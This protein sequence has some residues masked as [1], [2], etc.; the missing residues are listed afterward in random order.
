[1]GD[2]LHLLCNKHPLYDVNLALDAPCVTNNRPTPTPPPPMTVNAKKQG[3]RRKERNHS[4]YFASWLLKSGLLY[5][6]I[7]SFQCR[8]TI[9]DNTMTLNVRHERATWNCVEG[10]DVYIN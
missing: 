1:M 10:L 8:K 7:A 9:D 6:R 3:I 5:L 2:K 4:I